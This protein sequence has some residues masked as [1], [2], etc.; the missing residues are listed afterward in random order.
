MKPWDSAAVIICI[1]EAG[2]VVMDLEGNQTNLLKSSSLISAASLTLAQ[3]IV[4]E[5]SFQ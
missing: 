5:L 3:K 1:R 2:G 4:K